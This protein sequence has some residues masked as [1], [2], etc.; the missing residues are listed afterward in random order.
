M[1]SHDGGQ[2]LKTVADLL[3]NRT[4]RAR[5]YSEHF[6]KRSPRFDLGKVYGRDLTFKLFLLDTFAF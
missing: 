6:S 1:A 2:M 3:C 4:A 5:V